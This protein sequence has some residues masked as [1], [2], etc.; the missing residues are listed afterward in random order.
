[1]PRS[2]G[3]EKEIQEAML[4]AEKVKELRIANGLTQA[5]VAEKLNVTPGFISNVEN[6]RTAMSL[7]LL[8]Y[9]AELTGCT[10]DALVGE[11]MPE[12]K[13]T[14]LDHELKAAISALSEEE[15]K[16]LIKVLEILRGK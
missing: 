10:L 16:K 5:E 3:N 2:K 4:L 7:R 9:Y 11:M 12:Y 8:V 15:K 14:A 1:M 13:A 6:G